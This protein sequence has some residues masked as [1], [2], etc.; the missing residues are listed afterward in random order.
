MRPRF[1]ILGLAVVILLAATSALAFD[2]ARTGFA[3]G[4]GVGFGSAKQ[5]IEVSG[6]GISASAS[7][8]E[9]GVA[10]DFRLGG[11]INEQWILAFTS[12]QVFFSPEGID[13]TFAQGIA[14]FGATYFLQPSAPSLFLEGGIGVGALAD[15]DNDES[16]SGLGLLVGVGYEFVRNWMVDLSFSYAKVGEDSLGDFE[17]DASISTV[18]LTVG[19]LGY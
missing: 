19:W 6:G 3:L 7:N 2:G 1:Q 12:Q 4:F 13:G 5:T 16:D 8:D 15:L 14:G 10:T 11:G 17:A 18:R 9:G